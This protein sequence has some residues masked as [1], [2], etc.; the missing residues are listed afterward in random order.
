[1]LLSSF[2]PR[3]VSPPP[4][5]RVGPTAYLANMEL[6]Q[7][8]TTRSYR[9]PLWL[10]GITLGLLGLFLWQAY[11]LRGNYAALTPLLLTVPIVGLG[12]LLDLLL[13]LRY[14]IRGQRRQA[15]PYLWGCLLLATCLL[16]LLRLVLTNAPH[17]FGG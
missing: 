8:P 13:A 14:F 9:L 15:W 1:V 16:G 10:N 7:S 3:L 5:R 11:E 4:R 17:K 6:N 12:F 2:L